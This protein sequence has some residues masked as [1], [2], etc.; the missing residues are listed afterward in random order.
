MY[1]ANRNAFNRNELVTYEELRDRRDIFRNKIRIIKG[2][3]ELT[4]DEK[5]DGVRFID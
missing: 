3:N 5:S 4:F 2:K 1:V